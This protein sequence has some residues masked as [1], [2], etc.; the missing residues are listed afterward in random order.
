M[1]RQPT[2]PR[3]NIVVNLSSKLLNEA[4]KGLLAQ[5]KDVC[6]TITVYTSDS[7]VGFVPDKVLVDATTLDHLFP[8]EWNGANIIL[9]DTG[10]AEE[11]VI[12][13]LLSHKLDGVIST[14][15]GIDLFRKALQAIHGGQVWV[16]NRKLKAMLHHR[17]ASLPPHPSQSLSRKE[18]EIVLL[19]AEG[20]RNREIADQ[21][22]ISEQTVKTHLS[23]IFKKAHVTS[24]SQ[25]VPLALKYK[26]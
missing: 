3:M 6:Q 12:R 17:P 16:D 9:I 21:L 22:C 15:A 7:A 10:L 1:D 8:P 25:L 18:R 14:W 23:R 2:L 13:L 24:R 4:L 19:V 26:L 11:E 20:Q 5:D